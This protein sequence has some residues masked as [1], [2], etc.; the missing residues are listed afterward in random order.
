ME[1]TARL[2]LL[3]SGNGSNVQAVIDACARGAISAQV[4]AVI[5][6]R[7]DARALQRADASGIPGVHVGKRVD[8]TRA[9]YDA[10]LA[11]VVSGFS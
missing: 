10:R 7:V 3:A 8:E 11:D 2:V 5:S 6:D 4:S 1:R 9:D